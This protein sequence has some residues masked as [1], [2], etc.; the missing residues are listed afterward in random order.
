MPLSTII[1]KL[2]YKALDSIIDHKLAAAI[3][4]HNK[5]LGRPYCNTPKN[6]PYIKQ[7][8]TTHAEINAILHYKSNKIAQH[9]IDRFLQHKVDRL[10]QHKV[11]ILVIRV[12]R[13]NQRCNARPCYNC[14]LTMQKMGIRRVYYSVSSTDIV[15]EN[16]KDMISIQITSYNRLISNFN[17]SLGINK[18]YESILLNIF[19][20]E[21]KLSNLLKFIQYNFYNVLPKYKIEI[22]NNRVIITDSNNNIIKTSFII[23]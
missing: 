13:Y 3:I 12:N 23:I 21:I 7:E 1:D 18:Y 9:K 4:S 5:I 11:D 16:V 2:H 10:A 15:Y 6:I 22:N 8:G 20:Q 19:P 17:R 14:L